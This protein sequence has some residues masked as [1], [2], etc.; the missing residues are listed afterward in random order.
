MTIARVHQADSS[1]F[2]FDQQ[3]TMVNCMPKR[4]KCALL[5][6]TM[7]HNDATRKD[8]EDIVL[9]YK[10]TKSDVDNFDQQV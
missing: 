8:Q 5:L 4:N 1:M 6:S 2:C 7:H 3:L 9:F 10:Q